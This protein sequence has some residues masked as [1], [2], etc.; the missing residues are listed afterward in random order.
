MEIN[1][2]IYYF[3]EN[4]KTFIREYNYIKKYIKEKT[5]ERIMENIII[6]KFN[7]PKNDKR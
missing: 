2:K 3:I 6:K 4:I 7:L 1:K 5:N